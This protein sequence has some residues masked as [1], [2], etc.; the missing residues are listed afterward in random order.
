[1]NFSDWWQIFLKANNSTWYPG[2]LAAKEA[3]SAAKVDILK[4]ILAQD[5]EPIETPPPP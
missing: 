1:M 5:A 2:E 3:W 4:E